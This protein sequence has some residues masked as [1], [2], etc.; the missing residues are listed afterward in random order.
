MALQEEGGSLDPQPAERVPVVTDAEAGQARADPAPVAIPERLAAELGR[1][2]A[3]PEQLGMAPD[4]ARVDDP[5]GRRVLHELGAA[6]AEHDVD[7]RA[8]V[9]RAG[10]PAAP[11]RRRRPRRPAPGC[12]KPAAISDGPAPVQIL[13]P[14][15]LERGGVLRGEGAGDLGGA[16]RRAPVDVDVASLPRHVLAE[17]APEF[18]SGSIRCW[19]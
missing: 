11:P 14:V 6:A 1:D 19:P 12:E 15:A 17:R 4:D 10:R 13:A 18:G 7:A 3:R 9:R 16:A 8:D 5:P 2:A